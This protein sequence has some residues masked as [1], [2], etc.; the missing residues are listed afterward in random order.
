[1]IVDG[2]N[3]G[4]STATTITDS[5]GTWTFNVAHVGEDLVIKWN[6]TTV[7]MKTVTTPLEWYLQDEGESDDDEEMVCH[8]MSVHQDTSHNTQ[9]DCEAAGNMWMPLGDDDGDDDGDDGGG[10]MMGMPEEPDNPMEDMDA[11]DTT[12]SGMDGMTVS[13]TDSMGGVISA[14]LDA[15]GA[16]TS[17]SYSITE[18]GN[19][20][21]SASMTLLSDTTITIDQSLELHS[22]PFTLFSLNN[23][24]GDGPDDGGPDDDDDEPPFL[25]MMAS[26]AGPDSPTAATGESLVR[27]QME[28]G[29]LEWDRLAVYIRINDGT[30]DECETDATG[31]GCY[32]TKEQVTGN[33]DKWS[34]GESIVIFE[35]SVDICDSTCEVKV[36]IVRKGQGQTDDM[37]VAT[38][39]VMGGTMGSGGP[40]DGGPDDGGPDGAP[41]A[42]EWHCSDE[43]GGTVNM[44]IN[45]TMVNDGTEDCGDG[46]D[47][48]QDFDSDGTIDNWWHCHDGTNIT[49]DKI[50]DGTEDCAFGSDEGEMNRPETIFII[51]N[52]GV[53]DDTTLAYNLTIVLHDLFEGEN[54]T[55]EYEVWH[56]NTSLITPPHL[57]SELIMSDGT[58]YASR[59][60]SISTDEWGESTWTDDTCY[61]VHVSLANESGI[62]IGVHNGTNIAIG[63]V[64]CSGGPGDGPGDGGEECPFDGSDESPCNT[65][66]CEVHESTECQNY[67]ENYCENT[68]PSDPGCNMEGEGH[69]DNGMMDNYMISGGG[70]SGAIADYEVVL[71][72]CT[73]GDATTEQVCVDTNITLVL[74]ATSSPDSPIIFVDQVDYISN[75]SGT[76]SMGDMIMI[77]SSLVTEDY[78][79]VR[80]KYIP[81]DKYADENPLLLPGFTAGF[82]LMAMLGAALLLRRD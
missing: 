6:E 41:H 24:G 16:I 58:G 25:G 62:P 80:L 70:H 63:A 14:T 42:H 29:D 13:G 72:Q 48:P 78:N 53:F 31:S 77:N 35:G 61:H 8:D 4:F 20:S 66:V 28:N 18:N 34:V 12:W 82:S 68:N 76:L 60:L 30:P 79:T 9:E 47:E 52:N 75:K 10:N 43:V 3:D 21:V 33:S 51:D 37:T 7:R 38:L 22:L 44:S 17:M 59:A 64:D 73:K 81:A 50:N 5:S 55:Y 32:Y 67:V 46:S 23:M 74:S 69:G 45:W 1:M 56:M 57:V 71:S 49:A 27:V 54:Y 15:S 19:Y 36:D 65:T 11:N 2:V 40:D 26:S 39:T